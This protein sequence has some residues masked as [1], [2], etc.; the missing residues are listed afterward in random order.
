M[1]LEIRGLRRWENERVDGL[2]KSA[3][4]DEAFEKEKKQLRSSSS[5]FVWYPQT[6][7]CYMK[8]S[9]DWFLA[10]EVLCLDD[11]L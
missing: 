6:Q 11:E 2:N 5:D 3:V 7:F 9:T 1:Y 4:S 10:C 8:N